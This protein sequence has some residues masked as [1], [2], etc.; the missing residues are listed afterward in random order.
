MDRN[1]WAHLC[2]PALSYDHDGGERPSWR[3]PEDFKSA[4]RSPVADQ[5]ALAALLAECFLGEAPDDDVAAALRLRADMP[6]HT[7]DAIIRAL[8][9]EPRDRF[10]SLGDFVW[11]LESGAPAM[12]A[13]RPSGRPTADVIIDHEWTPPEVERNPTRLILG[14]AGA[15]AA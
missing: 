4:T 1:G 9:E 12:R 6:S 8:S 7:S 2:D 10:A 5:Y 15:I 11:A 14:V 3:A 13:A